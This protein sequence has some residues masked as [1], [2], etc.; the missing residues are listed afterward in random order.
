MVLIVASGGSA[1]LPVS[2]AG[3]DRHVLERTQSLF[4]FLLAQLN[5]LDPVGLRVH[6][7]GGPIQIS[8]VRIE[9]G[10]RLV[11]AD[12]VLFAVELGG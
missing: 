11:V 1:K 3:F 5:K 7:R 12:Q 6:V 9:V 10:Q 8:F 2:L 4:S